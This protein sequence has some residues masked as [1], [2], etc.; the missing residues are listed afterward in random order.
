[1]LLAVSR[2]ASL[3]WLSHCRMPIVDDS[4][5]NYGVNFSNNLPRPAIR[6]YVPLVGIRV[7]L[8][9]VNVS[10][11]A[12]EAPAEK[13]SVVCPTFAVTISVCFFFFFITALSHLSSKVSRRRDG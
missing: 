3:P 4:F 10:Y 9:Q 2:N 1:M 7:S 8:Q 13:R 5:G 6:Q 12:G 11:T